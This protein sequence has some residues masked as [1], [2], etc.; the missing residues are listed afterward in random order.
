MPA[1]VSS[2]ALVLL[3]I[4]LGIIVATA[5][6]QAL[7]ETGDLG[8][9]A[10][11]PGK[12]DVA[13]GE[14]GR[15]VTRGEMP[16][17]T[18]ARAV[19]GGAVAFLLLFGFAG[20]YIVIQDRGRS[21]SPGDAIAENAAP[22]IAVLP[23]EVQGAS[24]DVWREGVIDLVATNLDGAAGLRAIDARTVLARWSEIVREG[25]RADVPA[26][27]EMARQTGARFAVLGTAVALGRD[28]RLTADVYDL[29]TEESLGRAQ[30]EGAPDSVYML[31][32]QLS[33]EVLRAIVGADTRDLPHIGLARATTASLP[34][35]RAYL[36]GEVAYRRA[37]FRTAIE[38]YQ[39]AVDA[40]STFALAWKRLSETVGWLPSADRPPG[41]V[42]KAAEQAVHLA[43]RLPEREAILVRAQYA[44][45]L[46]SLSTLEPLRQATRR[47]PDDPELWYLLADFYNHFDE[48]SLLPRE[49]EDRTWERVLALDPFFAPYYIHPIENAF[50][51][52]D[53]TRTHRL[54]AAYERLAPGGPDARQFRLAAAIAW[55]SDRARAAAFA[56][57]DTV[58]PGYTPAFNLYHPRF[59][60]AAERAALAAAGQEPY[61]AMRSTF[62]RGHVARSL[63]ILGDSRLPEVRRVYQLYRTRMAGLPGA[64][65][66]LDA[67]IGRALSDSL[68]GSSLL[69]GGARAAEE[70]SWGDHASIVSRA[71]EDAARALTTDSTR[72]RFMSGVARALEGY[73]LWRRGDRERALTELQAAQREA[74]GWDFRRDANRVIRWW[75]ARLLVDMGRDREAEP[76]YV[77]LVL[78]HNLQDP[79]PM[80]EL[81]QLYERLGE[82]EKAKERYEAVLLEWK[83]ADP[84][85]QPRVA[86]A[87]QA[88]IRLGF[89]RRG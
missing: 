12:W 80:L 11:V 83:D 37:D 46:G 26:A 51:D 9:A 40:D 74:V 52:A 61:E 67:A 78:Y 55:G 30:V 27:L 54:L 6:V 14:L 48:Q 50:D 75:I 47:Y 73:G 24:L 76:Y 72:A 44:F 49:E 20:L 41:L 2:A 79:Y 59:L 23:F 25:T 34:G 39:A 60:E 33:V 53:S 69:Y 18:W 57:L 66:L 89:G 3:A 71:R 65:S 17:L 13:L 63:G 38:A 10:D 42:V 68:A 29:E 32:D 64:D 45:N 88:L 87:R 86:E 22:G 62:G 84:A 36:E 58:A 28:L 77:S 81:A 31:V 56:A 5:W 8:K 16:H 15:S 85:L 21:F 70:G 82:R 19:L 7:P 4:G 35:L 1:W 43:D